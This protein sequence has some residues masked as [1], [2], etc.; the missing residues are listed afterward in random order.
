MISDDTL[1]NIANG[2][3]VTAMFLIVAYHF[4]D[5]NAKRMQQK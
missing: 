1:T 5:V 2:L 3:G 4:V